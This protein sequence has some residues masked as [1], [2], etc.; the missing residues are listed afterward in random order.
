[1]ERRLRLASGLILFTYVASHFLGHA[2]GMF[3][4][5]AMETVGRGVILAPW[6]NWPGRTLLLAALLVHGGLG[7]YAVYK[8]RTLRM[9]ALEATQLVLGLAIPFLL[10]P[11]FLTAR[12]GPDLFHLDG[13]YQDGL[14]RIWT[15]SARLGRMFV[16]LLLVWTHG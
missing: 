10:T 8:R 7:L 2:T 14:Y 9:P 1:M 4:L 15:A 5:A 13:S 6:R 3:G 12:V 16:L 11:H